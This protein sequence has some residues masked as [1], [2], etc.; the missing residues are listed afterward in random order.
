MTLQAHIQLTPAQVSER[1]ILC[2]DPA[3]V[4]RIAVLLNDVKQLASQREFTSITG[5][6]QGKKITV[7]STGIG[8][9]SAI[10]AL[11]ELVQCGG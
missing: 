11:E 10:I 6:L 3:R 4:N 1:V 2:G 8:A 9:P 5:E 7:C